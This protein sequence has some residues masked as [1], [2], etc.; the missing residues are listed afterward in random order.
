MKKPEKK[1]HSNCCLMEDYNSLCICGAKYYNLGHDEM[2]AYY[3]DYIKELKE[4][5]G[6]EIM[7]LKKALDKE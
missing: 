1:L 7:A 3:H 5:H 4:K 2:E 6:K